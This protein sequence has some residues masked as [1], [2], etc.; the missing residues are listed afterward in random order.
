MT[1]FHPAVEVVTLKAAAA[2]ERARVDYAIIGG[3]A[4]VGAYGVNRTTDD[5]DFVLALGKDL[6]AEVDAFLTELVAEGFRVNRDAVRRRFDRG[7]NLLTTH[8]GMTR[9]DFMLK[10]PDAYWQSA[11]TH[12]RLL[13]YE[14]RELWFASPEDVIAL[15]LV[16]GRP[17][18]ILDIQSVLKVQRFDLDRARLRA[19]VALFAEKTEKPELP[20]ALERYLAETDA[21]PTEP[22]EE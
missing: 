8:L 15:K 7:P 19:T 1:D 9:I 18:D 4:A 16:A 17:Q 14:G 11:L 10:R 22:L 20:A 3:I 6:A 21:L 2:C 13:R 12:R 5:V